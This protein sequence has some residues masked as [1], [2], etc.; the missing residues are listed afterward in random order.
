MKKILSIA[1]VMV[2]TS[3]FAQKIKEAEVPAK[4]REAFAKKYPGQNGGAIEIGWEKEGSDYEAE[5]DLN[6]IESSAV[7]TSDGLFKELEQEIK[8]SELPKA[9][10][11]YCAK[12]FAGHKISEAEKITDASGKIS[13][14]AELSKGKEHFDIIFDQQGNF[15]RKSNS[16]VN[17]KDK[18]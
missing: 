15:I 2:I 7:F 4:V 18:D 12:N 8:L 16:S 9:A 5:F 11:D 3:S 6:K 14:E 1:A 17:E 13:Y 10:T